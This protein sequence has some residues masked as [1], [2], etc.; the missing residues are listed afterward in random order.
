MIKSKYISKLK[1]I[2]NK[3]K[4]KNP[5]YFTFSIFFAKYK[6]EKIKIRH[7]PLYYDKNQ[8]PSLTSTKLVLFEEV[9]VN[10]G[11]WDLS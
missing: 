2:I 3:E 4:D 6:R 11:R 5:T 10:E 9:H 1:I 7:V 8:I